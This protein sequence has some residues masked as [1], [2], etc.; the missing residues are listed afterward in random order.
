[1]D[2]LLAL[3][4]RPVRSVCIPVAVLNFLSPKLHATSV[5]LLCLFLAVPSLDDSQITQENRETAETELAQARVRGYFCPLPHFLGADRQVWIY[6]G[7]VADMNVI[8]V[9]IPDPE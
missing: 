6:P 9:F 2:H 3:H 5:A 4:R 7:M 1:M 8:P